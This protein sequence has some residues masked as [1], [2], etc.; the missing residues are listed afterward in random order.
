MN[1]DQVR[2]SWHR[3]WLPT[4]AARGPS[5]PWRVV[6]LARS[7]GEALAL[8]ALVFSSGA[9]LVLLDESA[10]SAPLRVQVAGV[11]VFTNPEGH[12]NLVMALILGVSLVLAFGLAFAVRT[13]DE[14]EARAELLAREVHGSRT[15]VERLTSTLAARDE[16]LLTVVHELRAPLTY[17]AGYAE[18]LSSGARPRSAQEVSEMSAAIQ[19]ASATMLR[20]VDDLVEAT[21]LQEPGFTLKTRPVDLSTVIRG[22][23]AGYSVHSSMHRFTLDLPSGWLAVRADPERIHQV[24]ANLLTNAV[25]YSPAGGNIEVRARQLGDLVRVEVQ[26]H[27]IGMA[28]EDQRRA[29]DRFYRASEARSLHGDGSGLGLSIVRDL[30]EAH[31]GH[32]GLVS[33]PGRGTT[34]WFTLH[35]TD[36]Y[37]LAPEAARPAPQNASAVPAL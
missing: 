29:F 9:L 13:R 7:A 8:V 24:L 35:A 3:S 37:A 26:D 4:D 17:V 30:V 15:S 12:V 14:M 33:R 19:S 22:I 5:A 18:L 27:G 21:R 2:Q 28:P 23:V 36:E 25:N 1:R 31:G 34:F 6:C 32:V 16:L 20:L 10:W 11:L